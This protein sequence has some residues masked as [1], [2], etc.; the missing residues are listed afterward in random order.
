MKAPKLLRSRPTLGRVERQAPLADGWIEPPQ[1]MTW[2][3]RQAARARVV[4]STVRETDARR[5]EL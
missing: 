3:E 2:Q 4:V 1:T 5:V